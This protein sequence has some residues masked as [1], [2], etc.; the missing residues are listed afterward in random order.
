[1]KHASLVPSIVAALMMFVPHGFAIANTTHYDFSFEEFSIDLD[2][3]WIPSSPVDEIA[4]LRDWKNGDLDLEIYTLKST[5]AKNLRAYVRKGDV[6]SSTACDGKPAMKS[7]R[8]QWFIINGYRAVTRHVLS[9]M[10]NSDLFITYLSD[11]KRI[12]EITMNSP[13]RAHPTKNITFT[14]QDGKHI[15]EITINESPKPILA[16]KDAELHQSVVR[17]FRFH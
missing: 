6:E 14:D 9:C 7:L 16:A 1:M 3:S 5:Q 2:N 10:T 17:A 8:T 13:E 12:A 4:A 11:G 15:S